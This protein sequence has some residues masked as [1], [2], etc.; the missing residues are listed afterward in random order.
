MQSLITSYIELAKNKNIT[1]R[2]QY[3][4]FSYHACVDNKHI[5]QVLEN[6]ISNA[7][8]YSPR[9]KNITVCLCQDERYVR[10]EI[11]DEG[12]GLSEGDQQ[13][14]FSKFTR[15]TPQPIGG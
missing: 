12:P 9:D 5:F 11:Q 13:K 10:C 3:Q 6:L 15:L 14:L 1:I 4:D 8:K 2:F 7:V